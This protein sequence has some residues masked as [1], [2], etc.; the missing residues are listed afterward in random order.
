MILA[1]AAP[2]VT[3]GEIVEA[4]LS[5]YFS[6]AVSENQTKAICSRLDR[7]EVLNGTLEKDLAVATETIAM[8]ARYWLTATPPLPELD[9]GAAHALGEKRFERFKQQVAQAVS[10]GSFRHWAE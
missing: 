7:L 9:R 1:A 2:S 5:E 8:F 6:P 4:A 10:T 3:I